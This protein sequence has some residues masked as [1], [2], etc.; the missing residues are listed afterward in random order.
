MKS[1]IAAVRLI[2]LRRWLYAEKLV[3]DHVGGRERADIRVLTGRID[4]D[5]VRAAEKCFG[6]NFLPQMRGKQFVAVADIPRKIDGV[7][8][9]EVQKVNQTCRQIQRLLINQPLRLWALLGAVGKLPPAGKRRAFQKRGNGSV[10]F[11]TP[12]LPQ[13]HCLPS[14]R[15]VV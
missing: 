3:E 4:S 1:K 6:G 15:M 14:K 8:R 2:V 11:Q 12:P 9:D 7:D 5:T 13:A 10:G